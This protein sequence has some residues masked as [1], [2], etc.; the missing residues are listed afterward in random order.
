MSKRAGCGDRNATLLSVTGAE[1]GLIWRLGLMLMIFRFRLKLKMAVSD[2]TCVVPRTHNSFGDRSFS[3]LDPE[4][5]MLYRQNSEMTSA[6]DS[7]GANWSRICLSRTLN[8]GALWHN[9]SL[10][11]RNI[12]TYLLSYLL[13][14]LSSIRLCDLPSNWWSK[15]IFCNKY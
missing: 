4:Y 10:R 8:H 6:L 3:L 2:R 12:L 15:F 13:S 9:D 1:R 14:G 7:I 5:A 11:L